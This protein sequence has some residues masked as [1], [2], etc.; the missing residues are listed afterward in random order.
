MLPVLRSNLTPTTFFAN[1]INRV[2][3]L[4]DQVFGNDGGFLSQA[5]PNLPLAIW[6]DDTHLYIEADMPGVLEND[7][8]VTCNNGSLLIR[9]ER[10]PQ[11]G[12]SYLYNGL[13]FGRFER[14]VALP[15]AVNTDEAE[16]TLI[17]GVLSIT[18]PKSPEA[19]TKKIALKTGG[20]Q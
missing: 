13:T 5:W 3:S 19:R 6:E 11:E 1:P 2:E 17:N 12:R 20:T 18:L 16:A 4:F 7:V 8:E 9:G 10:R 14:V 15:E